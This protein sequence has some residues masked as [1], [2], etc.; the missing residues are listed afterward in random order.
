MFL[1][2]GWLFVLAVCLHNLEEALWLPAWSNAGGRWR[3]PVDARAFRFAVTV[4]TLVAV[5]CALAASALGPESAG[6][7]AL[8]GYALA[9]LLNVAVPHLTVSLVTGSYCPGTATAV[10]LNFPVC[11]WLLYR[12]FEEGWVSASGFATAGPLTVV[13]LAASIPVLLA[14]GGRL[15]RQS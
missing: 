1:A 8:C 2:A 6:A 13:A 14:L 3:R 9:M 12:G 15:F 5:G 11:S 7:Y 4:L 10:L